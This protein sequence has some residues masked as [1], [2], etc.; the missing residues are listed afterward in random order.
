MSE[1]E[2]LS[3][4]QQTQTSDSTR[5]SA[6]ARHDRSFSQEHYGKLQ[7]PRPGGLPHLITVPPMG[8]G[9]AAPGKESQIRARLGG[10][11]PI[12]RDVTSSDVK[13]SIARAV[14]NA[15]GGDRPSVGFSRIAATP[16]IG[17]GVG[18][19]GKGEKP[20]DGSA[21]R[22][23]RAA[24]QFT[25]EGIG[26]GEIFTKG[27]PKTGNGEGE[28]SAD[29]S[30]VRVEKAVNQFTKEGIGKG[31][32]FAKGLPKT[33]NGLGEGLERGGEAIKEHR[34]VLPEQEELVPD[35]TARELGSTRGGE[36]RSV[37]TQ[38]FIEAIEKE[39]DWGYYDT[40]STGG[41]NDSNSPSGGHFSVRYY[42]DEGLL[43]ITS[44]IFFNFQ[45]GKETN[46]EWNDEEKE[47]WTCDAVKKVQDFWG[48]RY[49]FSN[50]L[51][52]LSDL[53]PVRVRIKVEPVEER[54]KAHFPI[55]VVAGA[56]RSGIRPV[57]IGTFYESPKDGL[58][59]LDRK[60][61]RRRPHQ[62]VYRETN[63]AGEVTEI[64]P[65][66]DIVEASENIEPIYF[67]NLKATVDGDA[68]NR[69]EMQLSVLQEALA[70]ALDPP[71][72]VEVNGYGSYE[73]WSK[74]P[75]QL[76]KD[77]KEELSLDE[78]RER[79]FEEFVRTRINNVTSIVAGV[80]FRGGVVNHQE[81]IGP[82]LGSNS[83][84]EYAED[85]R[86][87]VKVGALRIPQTTVLHEFG[88]IF[89]LADEYPEVGFH[90]GSEK[91]RPIGYSVSHSPYLSERYGEEYD[92]LVRTQSS[93]SES[94]MSVGEVFERR[95]YSGFLEA[96][97]WITESVTKKIPEGNPLK[98]ATKRWSIG[99]TS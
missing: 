46:R 1:F 64:R 29:G 78:I 11:A 96:L 45:S 59:T 60:E 7:Q 70:A 63:E 39:V 19:S 4:S 55:R 91:K 27:L 85:R 14:P 37:R 94:I 89:G 47:S 32:I 48:D 72:E 10:R 13:A 67:G 84:E 34:C 81:S 8:D 40:F 61:G 71:F 5:D 31:E 18:L 68:R 51:P 92:D 73:E 75:E 23:G 98:E 57:G 97:V 62:F 52:E 3:R 43:Q 88:H 50:T 9:N 49:T 82:A 16:G 99:E 69:L 79:E 28:K 80:G 41:S 42:P 65:Y 35:A 76:K 21:V 90:G 30:D 54:E 38:Q 77:E 26:K 58:E 24:N 86:V 36:N 22:I 66:E 74:I 87:E 56:G 15:T 6:P 12:P 95:H 17:D 83:E 53:P 25:K 93:H 44:R 33:E 20:A 2:F